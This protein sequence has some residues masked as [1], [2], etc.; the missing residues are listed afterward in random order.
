[1]PYV[2]KNWLKQL[3]NSPLYVS[4]YETFLYNHTFRKNRKP[5]VEPNMLWK[6]I[7]T[8]NSYL[9]KRNWRDIESCF[10]CNTNEIIQHI[11]Y[12]YVARGCLKLHLVYI[13][14]QVPL[15][16]LSLA[17]ASRS[18][19]TIASLCESKHNHLVYLVE[20]KLVYFGRVK[21]MWIWQKDTNF[22]FTWSFRVIIG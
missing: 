14:Q 16:Y 19:F 10:F 15:I 11:F 4:R 2:K 1:M 22:L 3:W 5:Q 13:H 21:M 8:K 9:V 20:S 12:C 7:L 17:S 6:N 18:Q